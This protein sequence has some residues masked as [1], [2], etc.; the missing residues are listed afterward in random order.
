MKYADAG[1][2]IAVADEAKQ[3]IRHH[4]SRTFTSAV[5]GGIGGFGALFALDKKKW[6]EP[7]LVSSADGVGTKLKVAM[8]MGVHSTVGGDLVNHC[9]ND[10]L[11]Q[12]AEPLFFLDY[13]AMGRL[14]PHIVEQL[15]EGMSR[16][17]RKAACALIGGETAEMPGF[18]AP[19]EYDLAGFIVGAV[20]RS[21][22]LTGKRVKPGDALIA[23]PSAGLHTNGF[24]LARKLLFDVA[25]LKPDTYVAE[26]GNKIGAELLKPHL[27]YAPALKTLLARG[28]ISALAHITGGGIPG[29]LP[30]VLPSGVKA[31]VDLESWP[32]PPIFKYLAKLGKIETDELLQSFNMGVGMI[33][34]VPPGDVRS[35]EADLKRR[36][37][38]FFRIGRIER[39]DSGKARVSYSGSLHL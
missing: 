3:R 16:A 10:I 19:G 6:K 2:N 15:V 36:R 4:A 32:V 12:G 28:W 9:V 22:L 1:V 37:E 30:R 18:Y 8:A 7:V 5:L 29:N 31:V 24:S 14:E 11:V 26:V 27:C 39:G 38:K 33:L 35:V 34:V 21:K 25:K 13:L 23:L 17:C 20:E